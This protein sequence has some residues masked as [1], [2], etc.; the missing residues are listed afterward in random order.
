MRYFVIAFEAEAVPF[1]PAVRRRHS[2]YQIINVILLPNPFVRTELYKVSRHTA[3]DL[4]RFFLR[5]LN[6][7]ECIRKQAVL[8][9]R[10]AVRNILLK[11]PSSFSFKGFFIVKGKNP[12][13]PVKGGVSSFN[14]DQARLKTPDAPQPVCYSIKT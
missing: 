12:S 14:G 13:R 7:F 8:R 11:T 1:Y 2:G 3:R 10:S 6:M 5:I 9:K 4:K